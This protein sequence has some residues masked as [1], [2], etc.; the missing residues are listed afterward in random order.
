MLPQIMQ[1][2]YTEVSQYP[3][4]EPA[5]LAKSA[6]V[7]VD[8]DKTLVCLPWAFTLFTAFK[9]LAPAFLSVLAIFS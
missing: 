5:L 8:L 1:Q 3:R 4:I 9:M 6:A 2:Q 7:G